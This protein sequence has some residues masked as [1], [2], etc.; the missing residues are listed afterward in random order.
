MSK[1][2]LWNTPVGLCARE[3]QEGDKKGVPLTLALL[4]LLKGK[5]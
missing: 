5:V 4:N 2:V 3:Q 1:E